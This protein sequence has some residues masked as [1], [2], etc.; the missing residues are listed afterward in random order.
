MSDNDTLL[1]YLSPWFTTQNE[2]IAVEALGY[3]LHKSSAS[4]E[5]LD[6][7]VRTGVRNVNPVAKVRTQASGQH[8]TRPDLVGV[9]E[10]KVERVLIEAK[11]WADLTPRQPVAYLDR[12]PSDGAAVLLFVAPDGENRHVMA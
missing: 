10:D 7:V 5:A 2:N 12:L 3:I 1:A 9:D 11:F 8:G 6:D 4:R